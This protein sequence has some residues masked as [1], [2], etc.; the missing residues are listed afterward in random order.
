[1]PYRPAA[2]RHRRIGHRGDGP[3]ARRDRGCGQ[4]APA[5][6]S[7]GPARPARPALPRRR[8]MTCQELMDFLL[9]YLDEEMAPDQRQVFEAH[10]HLCPECIHYI[11]TY[12][13]TIHVSR[14]ACEAR[15]EPCAQPPEKLVRAI[16]EALGGEGRIA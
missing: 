15:E 10:L 9:A 1:L 4:D 11:E 5:P 13:L 6:G 14:L 12:R 16:L 3:P 8:R 7:P 2:P